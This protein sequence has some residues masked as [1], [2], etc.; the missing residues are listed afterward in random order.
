MDRF[1]R[2]E[3]KKKVQKYLNIRVL[4]ISVLVLVAFLIWAK[5]VI[6]IALLAIFLPF[7]FLTIRYSKMIPNI[8]IESNTAFTFFIGYVFGAKYG[9]IYGPIVGISCYA[10]NSFISPGYIL[11]PI[12]AGISAFLIGL[13]NP[14]MHL[15]F[16][17]FFFLTLILRTILAFVVFIKLYDPVEVT[18]HQVTQFISNLIIYLPILSLLYEIIKPFV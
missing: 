8:S 10:L 12:V 18:M 3:F 5:Y 1:N 9:L 16:V 2:E 6:G 15:S 4:L 11:A 7:T 13:I 14:T 17:Q